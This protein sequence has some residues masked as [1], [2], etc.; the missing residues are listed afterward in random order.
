MGNLLNNPLQYNLCGIFFAFFKM[1]DPPARKA[2]RFDPFH[3]L[4]I[5]LV[6]LWVPA[7]VLEG[8]GRTNNDNDIVPH[9]NRDGPPTLL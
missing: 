8:P 6:D 1:L 4:S 2:S 7:P 5:I 9:L 3:P